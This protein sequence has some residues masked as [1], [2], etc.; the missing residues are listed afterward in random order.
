MNKKDARGMPSQSS[1]Q[2]LKNGSRASVK[3]SCDIQSLIDEFHTDTSGFKKDVKV[4]VR[5]QSRGKMGLKVKPQVISEAYHEWQ[6]RCHP[7]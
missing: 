4:R 2:L 7:T 3:M 6:H 5:K 1:S